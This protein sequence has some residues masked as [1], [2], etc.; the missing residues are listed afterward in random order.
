MLSAGAKTW[1]KASGLGSTNHGAN[2]RNAFVFEH[3]EIATFPLLGELAKRSD[4]AET[5]QAAAKC[6]AEDREMAATIDH[7]WENVLTLT[8]A[9]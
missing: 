1:V 7:N 5:E 9:G 8:L 3:F 4:D 6:L 2:A